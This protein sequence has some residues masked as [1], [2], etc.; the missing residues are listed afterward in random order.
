MKLYTIKGLVQEGARGVFTNRLV[1]LIAIT[2]VFIALTIF[3]T[4]YLLT[5]ITNTNI[6]NIQK[7]VEI[8]AFLNEDI[9]VGKIDK[10]KK[11]IESIKDVESVEYIS[12]DKG[13]ED[14]KKSFQNDSDQEMQRILDE[15]VKREDNPIPS[16]FAIRAS[17]P[18]A[19]STIKDAVSK[20]SEVYKVNDGNIVT[21]FLG[22]INKYTSIIG[23]ILMVVLGIASVIL[24]SNSIK[25]TVFVRRKEISIIKD[26]GATD[27]YIR[28]PFI[29]EGLCIG[30]I[31][32][33]LSILVVVGLFA[34]LTPSILVSANELMDG[35]MIPSIGFV[36]AR[37]MPLMMIIGAGIGIIGGQMS[38]RKYLKI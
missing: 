19:N 10:L 36:L 23:T 5:N 35:F 8:V 7:K 31:G 6:K 13:L 34:A 22:K 37:I 33:M 11:K 32:A 2:T 16:S 4:F 14:Y 15:V 20:Y 30:I 24:I 38:L 9:N 18:E 1:S 29:I 25:V 26:I 28:L 21:Q 12:S 3:G 17:N 27:N